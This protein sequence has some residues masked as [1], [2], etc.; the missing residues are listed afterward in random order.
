MAGTRITQSMLNRALLSDLNTVSNKL[1]VTQRKL[2]S[3]KEINR[4]S[5]D[6]FGTS[7]AMEL[8][9]ELERIRQYQ[10][11]VDD[12]VAWLD[13]TDTAL[14][15]VTDVVQRARE[16]ALKGANDV[17]DGVSRETLAGE[18]DQLVESL[19]TQLNANHAGRY[20]FAG[21]ATDTLPYA[22]GAVDAYAGDANPIAREI[23]QG[24]SVE[25]NVLGSDV[26]G[27][28]QAANDDKLLH[29][30][31]DMADHL[32]GGTTADVD[33]LRGADLQRLDAN[34]EE[35]LRQRARTGSLMH[36]LEAASTSLTQLEETTKGLLT[37]IEDADMA[38]TIV[39]YTTQQSVYQSALKAGANVMQTS[40][41]DFLR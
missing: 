10:R 33:A 20:V 6:P 29:V 41:L 22:Q 34:F 9:G 2:S 21:T 8:R 12:G 5:D 36:R 13:T 7:R 27:G 35:L 38:K 32:R 11:N 30:L 24:V 19:K 31:R 4:P 26:L 28:G 3:G 1:S 40:L 37:T 16:L 25:L 17:L 14:G 23:G 18:I 15:S 39:D